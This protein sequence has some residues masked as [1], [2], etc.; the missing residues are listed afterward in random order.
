MVVLPDN[1]WRDGTPQE[2]VLRFFAFRDDY[3]QF[4]HSVKEFLYK[5]T[6]A[7]TETPNVASRR[8]SFVATFKFLAAVFPEGVKTRKGMT[9]VN[10]FEAISVGAALALAAKSKLQP[11]PNPEWLTSTE[12]RA[13]TTGATNS[14]KRVVGRVEYCRDRFLSLHV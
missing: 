11:K 10:L 1:S 14:K 4:E 7:A 13:L 2:Y 12:L 3:K 8:A 9:P 5:Y 6:K